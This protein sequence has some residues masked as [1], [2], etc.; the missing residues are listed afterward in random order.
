M[1]FLFP[2]TLDFAVFG[3]NIDPELGIL[4]GCLPGVN[5]NPENER[6]KEGE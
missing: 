4:H 1:V 3:Y 6:G 5:Y 2:K